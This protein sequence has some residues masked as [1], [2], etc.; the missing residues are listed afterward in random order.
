MKKILILILVFFCGLA[1]NSQYP[2]NQSI[3]A[4][5][6]LVTSKG[7]LKGRIVNTNYTDTTQANTQRIRQYAGAQIY[8]TTGNSFWVRNST[9]TEWIRQATID[10]ITTITGCNALLEGGVVTWTN[11]GLVFDVSPATYYITCLGAFNSP[12]TQVTLSAAHATLPRLDVIA[13]DTNNAVVVIA[14]TPATDPVKPQINPNSQLELTTILIPALATEPVGLTTTI[15]YD[16]N[17]EWT[18]ASSGGSV[19]FD[20]TNNPFH[21]TKAADLGAIGVDDNV[22]FTN[23][24]S[25]NLGLYSALK[26]YIR[27]K[28]GFNT[29]RQSTDTYFSVSFVN[30][31]T[32]AS[33][34]A[35][36]SEGT[37][38]FT[39]QTF[40]S[41]QIVTIPLTT[42]SRISTNKLIITFE[43]A[44]PTGIYLDYIQLQ[45]GISNGNSPYI[46]NVFRKTAT[47][48]VFQVIN[49][50]PVFA[51][52]DSTGGATPTLQQVITA[53]ATLT[54][55]N[56]IVNDANTLTITGNTIAGD[57]I[58]SITSTST[59]AASNLQKGLNI[60]L[61]G[62][63]GTSA[64]TTFGLDVSNTHTG[65]TSVNYGGRFIAS[66]GA[67][68]NYGVYADGTTIGV[69]GISS[70]GNGVYATTAT[71]NAVNGESSG[72]G[73]GVRGLTVSG[74]SFYGQING[75][76]TNT[77][78][79]NMRLV[80]VGTGGAGADGIGHSFDFYTQTDAG[81]GSI[82]I[83]NQLISKWT[84]AAAATRTSQFIITGVNS[85]T[86]GDIISFEGNKRVLLY[87]RLETQ[88]GADVASVAGAIAVGLDGNVFELTGTNAVTLISN[89]NWGNGSEITFVFTSTATLTDGTANSGTDIGMELVGNANFVGSAGDVVKLVLAEIGGTQRWYM[90]SSSVN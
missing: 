39:N 6:T 61:S 40:G 88:Q 10:D 68:L 37:Y 19:N 42:L 46:T 83:S 23:G 43:A 66:G 11:T 73:N 12:Q 24:S 87:G 54:G 84:T 63:N 69:Y 75:A 77:V 32:G 65:T 38:G 2:G 72:S 29:P 50:V 76:S 4:D 67:S 31:T 78:V 16:Q 27:L 20:N 1:A 57:P 35:Y 25:V 9:A 17:V 3:G 64:Q 36:V 79:P 22:S 7:G 82:N 81:I 5:S 58:L 28:T 18:S 89:L 15:I 45:G 71:G 53:G 13:V 49:N 47:D 80:R 74:N 86:T 48:S 26:I 59:A 44:N 21:L 62:I 51:F 14:G 41:Y 70:A 60:S 90:V 8:T 33:T 56:T 85:A 55:D 52:R 30:T 34:T